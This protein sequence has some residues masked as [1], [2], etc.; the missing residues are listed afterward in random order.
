MGTGSAELGPELTVHAEDAVAFLRP[1]FGA[2]SSPDAHRAANLPLLVPASVDVLQGKKDRFGLT[3]TRA[4]AAVGR[5]HLGLERTLS[6]QTTISST[7]YRA[8]IVAF[9]NLSRPD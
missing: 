2:E 3:A 9:N 1:A 7:V 6:S 8:E 5:D 4:L